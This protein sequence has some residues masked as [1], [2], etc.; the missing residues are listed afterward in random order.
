MP[1]VEKRTEGQSAYL[2]L[3]EAILKGELLPGQRLVEKELSERYGLGRAAIRTALARLEQEGLVDS[4]P[5]RGAWVRAIGE[6][7]A[8]EILEA[9][10]ALECLVARHAARK[11]T[12]A[13]VER[14]R[15]ILRE[16][17]RRLAEGDLLGMS[18]LNRT[19]HQTLVDIAGHRTAARLIEALR[20]QGVRHQFRT[21][22]V[23]GRAQQSL[24]E[25]RRIVEAVA[26]HDEAE[27]ERAMRAHLEGVTAALR[28]TQ[29]GLP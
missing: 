5:Y 24:A 6:E 4:E 7:E 11:A 20:A 19:L 1:A 18:E 26:A 15:G 12:A 17:E 16:M 10:M 14:L 2:R 25:H 23:P 28:Q 9:R 3:R 22:L 21:I 29:G 8:L 13:D 27:A